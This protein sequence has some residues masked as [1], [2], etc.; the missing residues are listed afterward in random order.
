M[1]KIFLLISVVILLMITGCSSSEKV[2]KNNEEIQNDERIDEVSS[3]E[4]TKNKAMEYFINGSIFE[5]KGDYASAILEFQDALKY[6]TSA[7]IYYA[8]GK[9]YY[10]LGKTVAKIRGCLAF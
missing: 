7:G 4:E 10:K 3:P 9:N 1:T 2:T 5:T 8:L 6:D